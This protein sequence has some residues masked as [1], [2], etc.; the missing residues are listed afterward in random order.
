MAQIQPKFASI[1]IPVGAVS[2]DENTEREDLAEA[3]A[4]G[5]SMQVEQTDED[6]LT[7]STTG[8]LLPTVAIVFDGETDESEEASCL[9]SIVILPPDFGGY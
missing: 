4:P 9:T 3:P 8:A 5:S 6:V 1:A 2:L 7:S